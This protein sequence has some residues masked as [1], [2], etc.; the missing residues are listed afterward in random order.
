LIPGLRNRA[1]EIFGKHT[2]NW[3]MHC[4]IDLHWASSGLK[5]MSELTYISVGS[6]RTSC[7]PVGWL[8]T[9][10]EVDDDALTDARS[11]ASFDSKA[12]H[13]LDDLRIRIIRRWS[14]CV[15]TRVLLLFH[16]FEVLVVASSSAR[17]CLS[18]KDGRKDQSNEEGR[19]LR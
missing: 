4:D 17:G 1:T 9:L 7:I 10:L 2:D 5:S 12:S 15:F 18:P 8:R 11:S 13:L 19:M 16:S 3:A 6:G 14:M